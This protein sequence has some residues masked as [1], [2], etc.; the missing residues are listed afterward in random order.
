MATL[1]D[2][3]RREIVQRLACFETPTEV[4][5]WASQ[6]FE[7]DI[8]ANQVWHYDPTRSE[9]TS[10]KW[11]ELFQETRKQFLND[12]DTIPLSHRAVRLRKLNKYVRRLEQAGDIE[13]AAQIVKQAAREVGG[14]FTNKSEM[15]VTSDGEPVTEVRLQVVETEADE[16]EQE[17]RHD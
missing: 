15:D 6:E 3:E 9:D 14:A 12:L 10:L 1:R 13:T 17:T 4:A 11:R 16:F 5:E 8:T 7:K 2:K